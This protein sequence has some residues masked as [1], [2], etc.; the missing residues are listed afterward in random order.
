MRAL[1]FA[2]LTSLGLTLALGIHAATP[3]GDS[4]TKVV[5]ATPAAQQAEPAQQ[6]VSSQQDTKPEQAVEAT[7]AEAKVDAKLEAEPEVAPAPK[8][9]PQ[10]AAKPAAQPAAKPT[11]KP[12]PT[13]TPVT[14]SWQ[15]ISE[16]KAMQAANAY[17]ADLGSLRADFQQISPD[18]MVSTGVAYLNKPGRARFD[19]DAPSPITIIADGFWVV[20][21]DEETG[22]QD[23]YPL[24]ATPLAIL[25]DKGTDLNKLA[26]LDLLEQ[27]ENILRLHLKS[28]EE[29]GLGT[30]ILTFAREPFALTGWSVID[31]QGYRTRVLLS[32]LEPGAVLS[33]NLFHID[34]MAPN[35]RR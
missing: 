4:S 18:G 34:V 19:Y 25:L 13:P 16:T 5:A 1:T 7:E 11:A 3:V 17:L 6:D 14:A 9:T 12:A 35:R 21:V 30:L 2:T 10:P 24:S 26:T 8:P 23:R 33:P 20:L 31:A 32:A 27:G 29:P 28:R 15:P 22:T